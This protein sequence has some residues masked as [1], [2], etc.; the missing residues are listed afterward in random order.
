MTSRQ[1]R[2]FSKKTKRTRV[3]RLVQEVSAHPFKEELLQLL[4]DQVRDDTHRVQSQ[5]IF[6]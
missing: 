1:V 4:H 6:A 5:I 2:Y 3:N